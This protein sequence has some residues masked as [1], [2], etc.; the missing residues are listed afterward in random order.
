M[1]IMK[2]IIRVDSDFDGYFK[3]VLQSWIDRKTDPFKHEIISISAGPWR[4]YAV[5]FEKYPEEKR[6]HFDFYSALRTGFGSLSSD[7][8]KQIIELL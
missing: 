4:S 5:Q 8:I 1:V 7:E 3:S 2:P 6:I